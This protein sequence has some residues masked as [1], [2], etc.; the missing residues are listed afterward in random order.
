[1]SLINGYDKLGFDMYKEVVSYIPVL[2]QISRTLDKLTDQQVDQLI[3]ERINM[4]NPKPKSKHL[5]YLHWDNDY[6]EIYLLHFTII[7]NEF[8]AG[9]DIWL[10]NDDGIS[11]LVYQWDHPIISER[12]DPLD[13]FIVIHERETG[14][15]LKVAGYSGYVRSD[16][17]YEIND[18]GVVFNLSQNKL[19][20][21]ILDGNLPK[22]ISGTKGHLYPLWMDSHGL[23]WYVPEEE[24]ETDSPGS[25]GSEESNDF[26]NNQELELFDI[27]SIY[28][29]H[30]I[31]VKGYWN[32]CTAH[33]LNY[34]LDLADPKIELVYAN[35]ATGMSQMKR[36]YGLKVSMTTD[37]NIKAISGLGLKSEQRMGIDALLKRFGDSDIADDIQQVFSLTRV[38][39]I[40]GS[41]ISVR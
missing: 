25:I 23:K 37:G 27:L 14:A 22:L 17:R 1:M 9:I 35:I 30:L 11:E 41:K 15:Y 5:Y 10:A 33:M 24:L 40:N 21:T 31:Q 28:L 7:C 16:G 34:Q 4:Y 6:D 12:N 19:E 38:E 29:S 39:G 20:Q 36:D 2:D 26:I 32:R 8:I 18:D 13:A 3:A